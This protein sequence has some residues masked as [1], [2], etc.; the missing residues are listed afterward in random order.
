M[1]RAVIPLILAT[2]LAA[3]LGVG[4]T[5]VPGWPGA[6]PKPAAAQAGAHDA[7]APEKS[8]DT[9]GKGADAHGKSE[10]KD[11]KHGAKTP[12][13]TTVSGVQTMPPIVGPLRAPAQIWVRFEGAIVLDEIDAKRAKELMAE[14]ANDTL[15]Y[16]STVSLPEIEGPV[17]LKAVREDL[18]ERARIRSDGKVRELLIQTLVTQ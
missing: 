2:L 3:G 7:A 13:P 4:S 16:F 1:L 14:I 15:V 10:K 9:H 5:K 17:G 8:A 18:Y 6:A 12:P 11:D